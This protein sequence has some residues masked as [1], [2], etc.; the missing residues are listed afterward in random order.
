MVWVVVLVM[1]VCG[2]GFILNVLSFFGWVMILFFGFYNVIKWVVEVL[3]E[4]YCVEFS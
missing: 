4:N 3:S 1:R 2:F